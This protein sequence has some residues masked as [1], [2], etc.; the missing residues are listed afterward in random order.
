MS[1]NNNLENLESNNYIKNNN[2][3]THREPENNRYNK[4]YKPQILVN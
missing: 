1:N 2:L 4:M 3:L